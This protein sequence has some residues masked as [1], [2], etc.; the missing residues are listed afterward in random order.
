MGSKKSPRIINPNFQSESRVEYFKAPLTFRDDP[1]YIIEGI[2]RFGHTIMVA[3]TERLKNERQFMLQSIGLTHGATFSYASRELKND[4]DFIK[5]ALELST[6]VY[7]DL[8]KKWRVEFVSYALSNP[9]WYYRYLPKTYQN[10]PD[11]VSKCAHLVFEFLDDHY[12][13]DEALF[14]RAFR[15]DRTN[16]KYASDRIKNKREYVLMALSAD[17]RLLESVPEI[18]KDD[19]EIVMI[20]LVNNSLAAFRFVSERMRD[21]KEIAL[22]AMDKHGR[23]NY[24]YLSLRLQ[25]DPEMIAM[26]ENFVFDDCFMGC[27]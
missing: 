7:C 17:G 11:I 19:R 12:R 27:Q 20:A 6:Q 25:N 14:L 16:Y 13:D 24:E 1:E 8:S 18:F 22:L 10:D 23:A 9:C 26:K 15:R 5:S 2:K 21:D 3:T 4:Y